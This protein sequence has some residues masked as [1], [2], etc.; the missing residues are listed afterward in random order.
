[1]FCIQQDKIK[2]NGMKL[3]DKISWLM[4]RVQRSLFPHLNQCLTTP[5]TEQE[6]RLVSILE[7]VQVERYVPRNITRFQYPGRKPLD[8]Q[9]LARAF[10]AKAVYRHPTTIDLHRALQS[11]VNLRRI[12]GFNTPGNLPSES[13]FSR[14]FAEFAESGLGNRVHDALVHEYLS[15]ELVGH[16]S[17]DSTAI[18]GREKPVK[19]EAKE[20]KKPCKRG[21]PAKGEQRTPAI[22]KRLDRQVKQTAEQAIRELPLVCD[23]GTKKNAKGYKTSWNGY[24]LHLDTNDIGLPIS[25][26]V[27]SA[28]LHDSQVA[29][30]LIKLTSE[31]VVYLYDLMDAAYDAERIDEISRKF[32]HVPIIDKNGRGKEVVPMAQHE[33]ERY[34]IRSTAERANSR[35][36]EDFGANNVMVRGHHKVTLH[37]MFGVIV[38]F[39]DQL[40][41][42]VG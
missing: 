28:S 27:T 10:V 40:L 8:R 5:L 29:I 35:L 24:K 7:I 36:K 42:L 6:E 1:L 38:L 31:K 25:A 41:R 30:P 20:P 33:A 32:G 2:E 13:T 15:Q 37:L 21:R 26:L 16:I 39:S 4:R 22:E 17:R 18:I 19:K 11:T 14:A 12:C 34:K 23:R 3:T 9:A